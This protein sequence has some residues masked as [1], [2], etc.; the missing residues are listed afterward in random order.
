MRCPL[1][2]FQASSRILLKKSGLFGGLKTFSEPEARIIVVIALPQ[3][4][5]GAAFE[6]FAEA[7]LTTQTQVQTA[8]LDKCARVQAGNAQCR[9]IVFR[10]VDIPE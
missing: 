3:K 8:E 7:Y 5:R 6:F 2:Y 4:D 10:C 1:P 9:L